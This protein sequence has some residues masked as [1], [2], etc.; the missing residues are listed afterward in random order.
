MTYDQWKATDPNEPY[1]QLEPDEPDELDM[2]YEQLQNAA[3]RAAKAEERIKRLEADL[4]ECFL[5]FKD[6]SDVKD[7]DYGEPRPNKEMQLATMLDQTLH[8]LPF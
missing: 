7:G 5:Y 8:G 3:T 1:E 4:L 6:R 2:V